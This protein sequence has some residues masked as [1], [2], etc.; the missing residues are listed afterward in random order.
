[1]IIDDAFIGGVELEKLHFLE[2]AGR[3]LDMVEG[4]CLLRLFETAYL[5]AFFLFLK[6]L[7]HLSCSVMPEFIFL[8]G[9]ILLSNCVLWFHLR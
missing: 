7:I 9:S 4:G 5:K 8:A 6:N 3:E 1:M 2:L